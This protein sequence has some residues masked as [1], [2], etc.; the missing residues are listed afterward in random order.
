MHNQEP[1]VYKWLVKSGSILLFRDSDKIHLELDKETSES[2]LLTKEDAE[3]LISII[4]TLAEAIWNSPSYIKE[5]YQGQ[6]FKTA[7]ELVYWDLGQPMLYAGFNV[8]EQAIAINYSGDAVLKISVNYAVELI[9][10][11]TH[12]CKQFGV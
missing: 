12:F 8:N 2:C 5:P 11:L 10:I 6:L 9:Q 4:T 7:D 3:S 1:Q